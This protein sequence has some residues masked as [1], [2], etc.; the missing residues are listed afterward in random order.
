MNILGG[1]GGQVEMT[2]TICTKFPENDPFFFPK[3]RS[4]IVA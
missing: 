3:G 4:K 1:D 2:K